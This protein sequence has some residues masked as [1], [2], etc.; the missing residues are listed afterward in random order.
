MHFL[1]TALFVL[2][3]SS[4]AIFSRWG[5]DHASAFAF[6]TLRFAL[7]L[8]VVSAFALARG[9]WLPAPGTRWRVAGCG[10]L[11]I[12]GYSSCY[13]LAMQH[14]MT[15]GLL[16]AVLGVQP[17]LTLLLLERGFAPAR[18]AGLAL[19]LAGL[20]LVVHGSLVQARL[21]LPGLGF[22]LAALACTTG[23]AIM[24][25]RIAQAAADVLPLQYAVTLLL[26]AA[27]LPTQPWHV[28][29]SAGFWVALLWLALVISVAA[30][31]L[32]YRLIQAGNLVNVTSLFYLVPGTTALLDWLLLGNRMAPA[33]IA[34]M[35]AILLGLVLVFR[36]PKA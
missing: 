33:A 14:G 16:A 25:K 27:L 15:P 10:L 31:L 24:Q 30:T 22:A 2:L 1:S 5:L 26:C 13:F 20:V 17:V 9:H 19:A 3:W 28:D 18:L 36:Q 23:G 32:L 34:G 21:S 7:A 4:G 35:G 11:M 6:L 29:W 12:G 8:A